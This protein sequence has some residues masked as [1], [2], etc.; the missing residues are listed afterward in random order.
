MKKTRS[1]LALIIALSALIVVSCDNDRGV[2]CALEIPSWLSGNTYKATETD[3]QTGQ[4]VEETLT[5]YNDN[6]YVVSKAQS[7]EN[8]GILDIKNELI[9]PLQ[10]YITQFEQSSTNNSYRL[11]LVAMNTDAGYSM[12]F[13][14]NIV[15]TEKGIEITMSITDSNGTNTGG[16]GEYILQ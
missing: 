10:N 6:I 11:T 1:I 16:S 15:K 14:I 12:S 8:T 5:F 2:N 13:K 4:A 9:E 7:S 3:S